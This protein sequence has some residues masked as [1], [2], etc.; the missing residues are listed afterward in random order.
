M[1]LYKPGCLEPKRP[2]GAPQS[3][4]QKLALRDPHLSREPRDRL[5]R[6]LLTG[7]HD[8]SGD[9]SNREPKHPAGQSKKGM[10][11]PHFA[12]VH[13]TMDITRQIC[14]LRD[15]PPGHPIST[16]Y[17]IDPS[18]LRDESLARTHAL[19]HPRRIQYLAPAK[20]RAVAMALE[21]PSHVLTGLSAL[22][23]YGLKHFVDGC[24]TTMQGNVEKN[25]PA[26]A[27][28]PYVQRKPDSRWPRPIWVVVYRGQGLPISSPATAVV[29]AILHL[30]AEI[31][32]WKVQKTPGFS[33]VEV[34]VIQLIDMCRR[35]LGIPTADILKAAKCRLARKWISR[36]CALSSEK[37]DSPKETEMRLFCAP[38]CKEL[39]VELAEQVEISNGY[40]PITTFDLAIVDLKIAI[41]YDGAHHL[42]RGQRD[43]DSLINVEC[44]ARGWTVL[45]FTAGTL[46]EM[47]RLLRFVV[48]ERSKI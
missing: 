11:N 15:T 34:R 39:G 42:D 29:D 27:T 4:D 36:M 28:S 3:R 17:Y 10:R 2:S 12:P 46:G 16:T 24:D 1:P 40:R 30:R 20:E 21:R 41:M 13:S 48:K 45:R 5:P 31:H 23:I 44:A 32:L 18:W 37:A 33:D 9:F 6:S 8:P 19:N 26:S 7:R 14:R 25:L 43:K 38:I 35:Y 22:A 47:D